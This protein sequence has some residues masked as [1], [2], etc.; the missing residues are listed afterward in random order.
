MQIEGDNSIC[1][2]QINQGMKQLPKDNLLKGKPKG[3]LQTSHA[4]VL[5]EYL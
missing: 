1:Q 3:N 4:L 5:Y 2:F